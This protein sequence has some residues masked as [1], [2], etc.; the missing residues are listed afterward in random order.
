MVSNGLLWNCEPFD[1]STI[2]PFCH[3][4]ISTWIQ[5]F[6]IV[7]PTIHPSIHSTIR[8]HLTIG[9]LKY[10]TRMRPFETVQPSIHSI[11]QHHP[12]IH[13]TSFDNCTI[14]HLSTIHPFI[15]RHSTIEPF[16]HPFIHSL[17]ELFDTDSTIQH[18]STIHPSLQPFDHRHQLTIELLDHSTPLDTRENVPTMQ[19]G[20]STD[21]LARIT[22]RVREL[23]VG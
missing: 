21:Q 12:S 17:I 19:G 7:Q 8:H 9:P 15:R 3:P 14:P 18:Y 11:I 4:S 2:E 13:S 5:P 10:S 20:A 1:H 22:G 23:K 6:D 16:D